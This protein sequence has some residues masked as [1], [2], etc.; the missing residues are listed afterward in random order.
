[1]SAW[2]WAAAEQAIVSVLSVERRGS[3]REKKR[4]GGQDEDGTEAA[5]L[6]GG[7][8]AERGR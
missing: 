4:G 1:M 7:T 3:E 5:H 6:Q 2:T 8:H